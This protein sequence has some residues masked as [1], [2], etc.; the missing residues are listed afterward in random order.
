MIKCKNG[1]LHLEGMGVDLLAEY[2]LIHA[3]MVSNFGPEIIE[4][5]IRKAVELELELQKEGGKND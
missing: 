2:G 3:K 1:K 5:V 4:D